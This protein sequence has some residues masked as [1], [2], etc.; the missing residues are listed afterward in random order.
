MIK[1]S[2]NAKKIFND[3]Y[4]FHGEEVKDTF[5]RVA[6]EFAKNK[7]D[8]D[9]AYRLLEENIW[10]PNTPVFLNA[11]KREKDKVFSAC[12]VV[13]LEDSMTS[14]Y[15]IA[16]VARKIFQ[17]GSGIGIPIGR[18]REKDSYIYE[19]E[20]DKPPEGKS[21]GPITFM[22]LYDAV[23]ETTKS[24]GRVR[25][26]AILCSM[27]V[28]HPDIFDFITCKETDG[29]LANMNISI[30]VTDDFMR[31]LKEGTPV[32]LVSPDGNRRVR[33][34]DPRELWTK[35]ADM[36]HKSADPG[37]IFID[38]VNKY[39]PLF[40]DFPIDATN[41]CGEQ[42]L[43]PF[44]CCNLSAINAHK[45]CVLEKKVWKFDWDGFYKT[46]K[47]ITRLMDNLID[48]MAFPDDR[49]KDNTHKYRQ[50]GFG[51]MGLADTLFELGLRYDG[52]EGRKFAS[53]LMKTMTTA[54]IDASAEMAQE[55]GTFYNYERYK[56]D[57]LRIVREHTDNNADVMEKVEKYGLRNCQFTTAQPTGTTA[58]SCDCSYGIEPAFGLVFTKNLIS[59]EKMIVANPIF[60]R[61]FKNESWYTPQLIEKICSNGGSLK[62]L[63]G[64]PREI[65]DVYVVA[66]DI[67]YKERIDMQAELQRYCS[68]AISSTV[69]LPKEITKDEVYELF[70]YAYDKGLKGITI[71]RDGCKKFQPVTFSN[72]DEETEFKRPNK[73]N[74]ETFK[75]ETGNGTMYV[76]V[77]D[78]EGKPVEVFVFLGKSGQQL[79][80]FTEALGRL[81]SLSLQN[82]VPLEKLCKTLA[83]IN[84]DMS[85]WH[86]FEE[87]DARPTQI[88][89][90][91]DGI[92]KLLSKYYVGK[93][94]KVSISGEKCPKCDGYMSATEGCFSCASCGY[95][96]CS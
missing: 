54:S 71:Y 42:P 75:I 66:H 43:L 28:V 78:D 19:S 40:K 64:V 38:N 10:R 15:D 46:C 27:P 12:Y 65:K 69:N 56:D 73:L 77:T 79:N 70:I 62:G 1:L 95:S 55:R 89:S 31:K 25:R 96:K 45:F 84:S 30:L 24:G 61:K 76:T 59:N 88:L 35:L 60:E 91:P 86:R 83:G 44:G 49:F 11:G 26:A 5:A 37:V 23:G 90:I 82:K 92:A 4:C 14:I 85:V 63:H 87:S 74:S 68:T 18:L 8:E 36:A 51:M 33:D 17:Y 53:D 94:I 3:L 13:G 9:I 22:K 20:R 34:I 81:L 57:M 80:T 48:N 6:K 50:I 52:P 2:D 16:N 93:E 29:R 39:N 67:K 7:E 32:T 72:T 41:P 58:L 21:S 47:I